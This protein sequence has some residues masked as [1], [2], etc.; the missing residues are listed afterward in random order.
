MPTHQITLAELLLAR[1][2][3]AFLIAVELYNRPTITYRTESCSILL[4]NAWELMLKARIVKTA[5]EQALYL[6]GPTKR[7]KSMGECLGIVITNKNDPVR[8]NLEQLIKIRDSSVHFIGASGVPEINL[9]Y[10]P[11]IQQAVFNYWKK[12]EEYHSIDISSRMP[13][14]F[15]TLSMRTTDNSEEAIRERYEGA[16]ADKIIEA[17]Q[18]NAALLEKSRE[19][20]FAINIENTLTIVKKG[21]HPIR[22][23]KDASESAAIFK[24]YKDPLSIF[25]YTYTDVKNE[26]VRRLNKKGISYKYKGEQQ[27]FSLTHLQWFIKAYDAKSNE[28]YSRDIKAPSQTTPI[29][30]YSEQMIVFIVEQIESRPETF[31]DEIAT[32]AK[33]MK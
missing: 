3:E 22:I 32:K 31:L 4:C 24:E 8:R 27:V 26:V 11:F 15:L 29:H 28:H 6:P 19:E 33:Q 13:H 14:N 23:V 21:G 9:D 17:Q 16:I 12:L 7:T 25:K 10:L 18:E 2:Q 20:G 30:R 5:G 1:S